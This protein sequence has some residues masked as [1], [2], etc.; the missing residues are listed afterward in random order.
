MNS[1]L[2]RTVKYSFKP[3]DTNKKYKDKSKLLKKSISSLND[4]ANENIEKCNDAVI[5]FDDT[6][7]FIGK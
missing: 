1:E 6:S 5:K 3:D 7:K 4:L 2:E